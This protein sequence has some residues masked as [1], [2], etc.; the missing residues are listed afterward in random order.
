[1]KQHAKYLFLFFIFML[2]P[3]VSSA[4]FKNNENNFLVISDIHLDQATLHMMDISPLQSSTDNDLDQLT[5]E[6]LVSEVHKNIKDG[7]VAQP[8][9]IIILGDIVGHM[10]SSSDSALKS[11]SVVFSILK[12]NFPYTPIFYTFGNNDSL[13]RNYGPF[14]TTDRPDQYKSPYDVAK[15][16]GGWIDGFLSTGIICENKKNNF[17]CI[18]SEDTTNGYYSAYLE[19]NFRFI[20]LN[21]VLFSPNRVQVTEQD[22]MDHLQW[23]EDQLKAAWNN[24]ESVLIAMHVPPG[25]NVYD[26]SH[27]WLPKEQVTF[28][29]IIKKYQHI[30]IGL[31][32]SHTHAEELKVIQDASKKNIT[33]VYFVAALSTSHGNEP[34]VKTFYFSKNGGH[35]LLSNYEVFHFSIENSNLIFNKLYDYKNYYCKPNQENGLF[36]CLDNI[37]PSKMKKYFSAGNKNYGGIMRSPDDIN[38]ISPR[39]H[40]HP[41]KRVKSLKSRGDM[42][43]ENTINPSPRKKYSPQFKDQAVERAECQL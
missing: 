11:E 16:N 33:G 36:Q 4:S 30:I 40:G 14:K 22:A 21:S 34:S 12:K 41:A 7:I 31:L 38:L 9:F 39:L 6:K 3:I 42:N 20:S 23:L 15:L 35:W 32:A 10:R 37:T 19:S 18:I 17:P 2:F 8:K 28:L 27:F 26:H 13:E 1:M 5:F 29:K 25:N 43:K 24:Q